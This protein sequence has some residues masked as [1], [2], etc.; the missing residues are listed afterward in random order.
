MMK[1]LNVTTQ[2]YEQAEVVE[3]SMSDYTLIT[4]KNGWKFNWKL[5][6]P[7]ETF[8]LILQLKVNNILGLISVEDKEGFVYVRLLESSPKC[9]GKN[10]TYDFI[11][12]ILLAFACRISFN[13]GFQGFVA[14]HP[15]TTLKNHYLTFYGAKDT[16]LDNV[17]FDTLAAQTLILKYLT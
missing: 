12:G 10:K 4:K 16:G 3:L 1:L 13:R 11:A 5:E 2:E 8:K 7:F 15:K 14:L 6:K 9:V 17:Y